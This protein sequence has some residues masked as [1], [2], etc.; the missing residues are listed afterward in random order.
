MAHTTFR[1][2]IPY[3]TIKLAGDVAQWSRYEL[4]SADDSN[5]A[6]KLGLQNISMADMQ[7]ASGTDWD[8]GQ[9]NVKT[10]VLK[11]QRYGITSV[12][13]DISTGDGV[14]TFQVS[15]TTSPFV[16]Q[17][18]FNTTGLIENVRLSRMAQWD[19]TAFLAPADMDQMDFYNGG[20]SIWLQTSAY[21]MELFKD[22][23]LWGF[24]VKKNGDNSTRR[25]L[26][27][28][29]N[30]YGDKFSTYP[31]TNIAV[32]THA[33]NM[34]DISMLLPLIEEYGTTFNTN[35]VCYATF[36]RRSNS[37]SQLQ[38]Q[39]YSLNIGTSGTLTTAKN[40]SEVSFATGASSNYATGGG[41]I[42]RNNLV[43]VVGGKGNSGQYINRLSWNG[44]AL[45]STNATLSSTSG[46]GSVRSDVVSTDNF[47]ASNNRT[48]AVYTNTKS[49][50]NRY[51]KARM[52]NMNSGISTVGSEFT[53]FDVSNSL[54]SP[55]MELLY[56]DSNYMDVV[57]GVS[58]TSGDVRLQILRWNY[59]GNTFQKIGGVVT[60]QYNDSSINNWFSLSALTAVQKTAITQSGETFTPGGTNDWKKRVY[61]TLSVSTNS[62]TDDVELAY[63][64]YDVSAGSIIS[65]GSGL[66]WTGR[67]AQ[68]A[69]SPYNTDSRSNL[70]NLNRSNAG[71]TFMPLLGGRYINGTAKNLS[72]SMGALDYKPEWGNSATGD[73]GTDI[74]TTTGLLM[75]DNVNIDDL[76]SE[77]G[78]DARGKW[79]VIGPH[80]LPQSQ[81][82]PS[83]A[84]YSVQISNRNQYGMDRAGVG[85]NLE[86]FTAHIQDED[87]NDWSEF[88]SNTLIPYSVSNSVYVKLET[89]NGSLA[90][91]YEIPS[92]DTGELPFM[93]LV[94]GKFLHVN[95]NGENNSHAGSSWG[96]TFQGAESTFIG[97]TFSRSPF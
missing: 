75:T 74:I 26:I 86:D 25:T 87:S 83:T 22:Q 9:G 38:T 44:S 91:T 4:T 1:K 59:G 51:V 88:F 97:I 53:V 62:E 66:A 8:P 93:L 40:G 19:Y 5:Y 48:I 36:G 56:T 28:R 47:G 42:I 17:R 49:T 57:V 81:V 37:T 27:L 46:Q 77:G 6:S 50:W 72:V 89:D 73:P 70:Y 29:S 31:Q 2:S 32:G 64:Y 68:I 33:S 94:D 82:T 52:Y 20:S 7:R 18:S 69:R 41:T 67:N 63:F 90:A 58:D 60:Y 80:P 76:S 95:W 35:K 92:S 65:V 15:G 45:S 79:R 61:F 55:N 78:W 11:P 10:G 30:P 14:Y 39:T 71:P 96:F 13:S 34:N 54:K 16:T 43:V 21:G 84:K 23:Q 85:T 3:N 12:S 24:G